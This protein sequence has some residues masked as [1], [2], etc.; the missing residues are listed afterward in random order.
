VVDTR[1]VVPVQLGASLMAGVTSAVITTPFDVVKTRLQTLVAKPGYV[2]S[3]PTGV[4]GQAGTPTGRFLTFRAARSLLR[5]MPT[6]R[7]VATDLFKTEGVA[8]FARGMPARVR[9]IRAPTDSPNALTSRCS[10]SRLRSPAPW[11]GPPP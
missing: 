1:H 5:E 10:R 7:S 11:S 2:G 3:A 4:L 6:F 9:S 8:G